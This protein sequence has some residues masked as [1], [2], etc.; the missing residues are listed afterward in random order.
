MSIISSISSSSTFGCWKSQVAKQALAPQGLG[1]TEG[2][3][4]NCVKSAKGFP[5]AS[6]HA[7]VALQPSPCLL[8]AQKR[9]AFLSPRP[10]LQE[11]LLILSPFLEESRGGVGTE[12]TDGSEVRGGSESV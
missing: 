11:H 7:Q 6:P 3:P 1:N 8:Q 9:Q 12:C 10:F 2:G 5:H 4:K